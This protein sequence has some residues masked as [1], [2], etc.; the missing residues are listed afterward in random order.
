MMQPSASEL[1]EL[2]GRKSTIAFSLEQQLSRGL[3][4]YFC[5]IDRSASL[6]SDLARLVGVRTNLQ[7]LAKILLDSYRVPAELR[8]VRR[9]I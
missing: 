1:G 6:S 5:K 2:E 8:G 7:Q 9:S 3:A 4:S